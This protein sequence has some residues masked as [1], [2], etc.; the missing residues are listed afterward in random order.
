MAGIEGVYLMPHP[1]IL[2]PEIGL[3]RRDALKETLQALN[4][5]AGEFAAT[6]PEVV[7]VITP[8]GPVFEDAFALLLEAQVRGDFGAFRCPQVRMT[9]ST[10][11]PLAETILKEAARAG[12]SAVGLNARN[13]QDYSI[14]LRLDW[15]ALVPLYF[16]Q[17]AYPSFQVVILGTSGLPPADLYRFGRVLRTAAE[18]LSLSAVVAASG[19]MSHRLQEDGPYG[20]HPSGPK[21]DAALAALIQAGDPEGLA[22]LDP[23]LIREGAACATAS[24][25][26]GLGALDGCTLDARWLAYEGPFGVGYGTALIKGFGYRRDQEKVQNLLRRQQAAV[27][28][29]HRAESAYASLARTALETYVR[30]GS[31][32]DLDPMLSQDLADIQKGA[33]V[34]IKKLGRL[35]GCIGTVEPVRKNLALEIMHNAVEAGLRDPRFLPV[36]EAELPLLTYSVDVLEAPEEIQSLEEL[37]VRTYGVIVRYKNRRG[38]LLPDLEG[39]DTPEDQVRIALQKAG[40]PEDA[41]YRLYRFRVTRHA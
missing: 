23:S 40:I 7:I 6:A 19:D 18:A 20:Y 36:E 12:L 8:H 17:K 25:L 1:P 3:S 10:H 11:C 29:T 41:P 24:W 28:Q 30:T 35:R 16:L 22:D 21:L 37:E 32:P 2:I 13:A 15:G 4:Q 33:F 38:L 14:D 31:M 27:R 39:V 34:S 9:F 5:V 26:M